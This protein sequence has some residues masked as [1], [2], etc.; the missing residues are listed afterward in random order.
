MDFS[1]SP[2]DRDLLGLIDKVCNEKFRETAFS[3]R[4]DMDH[5][6][7][8]MKLLGELGILGVCMPTDVGGMGRP[9]LSGV[10]AIEHIAKAC[11][12]TGTAALMTIAGPGIFIA[13]WG[14]SEQKERYLGPLIRGET[15]FSISLTEPQAGTA[16][17]DLNADVRRAG[18]RF[19]LTGHKVFCSHAH[20]T[21]HIL[22]FCRFGDGV[23]GIGA[24]IV[25]RTTPGLTIG[26]PNQYISGSPWSELYFDNA[27]IPAGNILFHG[28]AFRYL[29][30]SYSLER[31]SAGAWVLGVAQAAFETAAEY[32]KTRQQFGRPICEFEMVQA[33]LADMYLA[34]EQSRLLLYKATIT[35][36]GTAGRLE[37]SAAK[38]ATT[39]AAC[40]VTDSAMQIFGAAGMSRELPL[41]WYYRLVR[42][43]TVAGGTSDIHRSMIASEI[44]GRRFDHRSGAFP[45]PKPAEPIRA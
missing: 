30:A 10:L 15:T 44:L 18:D 27:E 28:N 11:P 19:F 29:M 38:V 25:D 37:S 26:K 35:A 9:G 33:R 21:D 20:T 22:V 3:R 34:L 41:E 7:D 31:A 2:E 45:A 13:K 40:F 36:E 24:V 32:S 8:N 23:N 6:M 5:P 16:L 12:M 4:H 42:P 1:V 14:S 43:F 39:E 17:T